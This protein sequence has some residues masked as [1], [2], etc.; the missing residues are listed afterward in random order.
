VRGRNRRAVARGLEARKAR[1]ETPRSG[2]NFAQR[3]G[4]RFWG[5][6]VLV[7]VWAIWLPPAVRAGEGPALLCAPATLR[8][9]SP[10]AVELSVTDR[11]A[12]RALTV[13]KPSALCW[14]ETPSADMLASYAARTTPRRARRLGTTIALVTRFGTERL[15]AKTL[16]GVLVP[17]S[18]GAASPDDAPRA[19]YLVRGESAG[20]RPRVS[21]T[22]AAGEHLYDVGRAVRLC[23]ATTGEDVPDLVCHAVRLARTK[24]LAQARSRRGAVA[25]TNRF[26]SG[27]LRVG[28]VRELCVPV[29]AE[30]PPPPPDP[31]PTLEI[32]P[33]AVTLL[34]GSRAQLAATAR[35]EDGHSTDV[36]GSVV[37]TS[38]DEGVARIV[39]ASAAGAFI[40]GVGPGTAVISV[41][42]PATGASSHDGGVDAAVEVTWPLEKLTISPHA[43]TKRPGD[44]EGYTVT[45]H[46]T[47]GFTQ[48]LTQRVVYETSDH[49]VAL[50]PNIRGNRS[51]IDAISQGTAIVSATDPISGISTTDSA[52]DAT[53][54]VAGTLRYITITSNL[55][56]ASRAVGQSQRFT[57]TGFFSDGSVLNMTQRCE[58]ASSDPSVATALN[59]PGDLSRIVAVSPGR[60]DVTCTDPVTGTTSYVTP[61]WVLGSLQQISVDAGLSP[62]E[63]PRTGQ[64]VELTA[65]G[66]YEGGGQR[67][68]TQDVV[69]TTRDPELL[70]CPNEPGRRSRVVALSGGDARVYATEPTTG[71]VSPDAIV[72]V[73]GDL[74][75]LIVQTRFPYYQF[76]ALPLGGLTRFAVRGIFEH[77]TL[78]LS[79]GNFGY[80]LHSSDP[81]VATIVDDRYVHGVAPGSFEL[82]ATDT[83][84]GI[85]SAPL[86]VKVVGGIESITLTPATSTRGI[87]EWES[88]TAVGHYPPGFDHN[89]T[90]DLSYTSSDPT[91]AVAD[92]TPGMRSRVRTIGAGTATITATD[93][94]TGLSADATI[95]VLP[96]TIERVTIEPASVVVNVGNSFSY[97]A[98]GHYPDGATI[99]VTQVV[100]WDTLV[101]DVA[102]ATNEPS[103]RSRVRSLAAGTSGVTARHPSGVSS[104]DTGDDATFVAKTLAALT[105]T[106]ASHLGPVGMVER[107]TLVGTFDDASTINLT[108]DA[109][110]W[111]DDPM[112]ARADSPEGDRSA[113]VLS[114]PGTTTVHAMLADWYKEYV[115]FYGSAVGAFLAVVP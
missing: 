65:V 60:T 52:N 103:N 54:R 4:V 18:S 71:I 40:T 102:H 79:N 46:F 20:R 61:F 99:N 66:S 97:T 59:T 8:K 37:W 95:T 7:A 91:V 78:N 70:Q 87:G 30:P 6:A 29:V 44:H 68:L 110:Y 17:S 69:W 75:D 28:E 50:A 114:A 85:T 80:V 101:P 106:P 22:D 56:F 42:D 9:A 47:G 27:M 43:V 21:V 76:D 98:I 19:C 89:V 82:T 16:A 36:T 33:A 64:S 2:V 62:A 11:F 83:V 24:P 32:A 12:T 5:G 26:G 31:M 3:E 23:V 88:F 15:T 67:N 113:V 35:D 45:G 49:H 57:A 86:T 112:V 48:N 96:G 10:P 115:T 13:A 55:R 109:A 104:H 84:T 74:V 107:Y 72:H 53:L 39:S 14:A 90:Q 94:A 73:L 100:T 111:T 25:L 41:A 1:D 63:F 51:S 93:L 105:L 77:G 92:N 58:W 34:A 108:Q 81:N 38:S